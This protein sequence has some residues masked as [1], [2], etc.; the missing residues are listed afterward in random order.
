MSNVI[1]LLAPDV[2][3]KIAAGEVLERPANLLKELVENSLDAG[4]DEI[5]IDFDAGGREICVRDNGRGM[6]RE[7]L[8]LALTRH[9]TSKISTSEDLY[10]LSSYGFRGEALASVAAVSRMTLVSRQGE[11]AHRLDC[12]FGRMGQPIE[13]SGRPGTEVRVQDLFGNVPARLRFL[14]SDS[15]EHS[16]IKTTLRALGLAREDVGFR[17]R[18]RNELVFHWAK[19]SSFETRACDVLRPATLFRGE[20]V[21]DGVRAEVLVGSPEETHNVNRNLWFFVQGRWV[22]D[23]SLA[24]AVLEGYRNL[25]MHGQYPTAVVRLHLPAEDLDANVH[26]TKAQVKFRD[27]RLVFRAT[28]RAIREVLERAPWLNR[29]ILPAV[30]RADSVPSAP[31]TRQADR[32]PDTMTFQ[33][34]EFAKTQYSQKSFPLAQVREAVASYDPAPVAPVPGSFQWRNLQIVGQAHLTYI[35]AQSPEALY[36]VDQHAAQERVLFERLMRAFKLG[37]MDVQNLLLPL[38]VDLPADELEAIESARGS[39]DRLGLAFERMGPE[40]LAVSAIP[41]LVSESAVVEALRR[42]GFELGRCADESAVEKVVGDVLATM[43]CHSSVRA[44]QSLS[45]EQMAGLLAQM[46]DF[47]LSSFCPHGRPVS[48][49][50]MFTDLEREFGRLT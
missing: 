15:A 40:S 4:A 22:Q 14:K 19:C 35:V 12:E 39:V 7:D 30:E 20:C 33:A 44:G 6:S 26:P 31:F 49:R 45:S 36:L 43:A 13:T 37:K 50:R 38:I 2:V 42:L 28:S 9:A 5:E 32:D 1:H 41:S 47:P 16:Q 11:I 48:V 25:L 29:T 18:C 34:P 17:V 8:A 46:D 10:H 27:S 23:R 3:D 21:L 24:A